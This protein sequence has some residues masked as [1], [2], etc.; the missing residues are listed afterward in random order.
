MVES[1]PDTGRRESI[2]LWLTPHPSTA[3]LIRRGRRV[4]DYLGC[5]CTAVYAE[6][7]G[8]ADNAAM[9]PWLNICRNL[10][11]D[12]EAIACGGNTAKAVAAYARANQ[13][14][15]IY[16]TRNAPDVGKLVNLARDMQ[17][18]IVAARVRRD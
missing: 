10:R 9:E 3:I 7:D 18:T 15:Q 17:I 5:P 6:T 11:I 13:M 12:A 1:G 14:T 2:L 16:V 8:A 4:A